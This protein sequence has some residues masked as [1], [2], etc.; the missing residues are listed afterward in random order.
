MSDLKPLRNLLLRLHVVA[1]A[2]VAVL[3]ALGIVATVQLTRS[4]GLPIALERGGTSVAFLSLATGYAVILRRRGFSLIALPALGVSLLA[5][6]LLFLGVRSAAKGFPPSET[7]G[8][9]LVISV[10]WWVGA[11]ALCSWLLRCTYV[12]SRKR[13]R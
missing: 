5:V 7:P 6:G 1:L 11:L 13:R 4:E 10:A 8:R 12:S 3:G 9:E 2:T